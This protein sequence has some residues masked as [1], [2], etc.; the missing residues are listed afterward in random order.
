MVVYLIIGFINM[1]IG[2]IILIVI[3]LL[4]CIGVGFLIKHQNKADKKKIYVHKGTGGKY[5]PLYLCDMKD[6][7]SRK[8]FEAVAYVSLRNGDIYI[9]EKQDFFK[10][11]IT[12][13]EWEKNGN[14]NKS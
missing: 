10:Q 2:Q 11:F 4:A 7:T 1:A 6:I 12:L 14:G 3:L 13:E 9:R 8:W 5:R